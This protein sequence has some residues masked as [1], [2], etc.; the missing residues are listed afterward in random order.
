MN[1]G[2]TGSCADFVNRCGTAD[3]AYDLPVEYSESFLRDRFLALF[4]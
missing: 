4:G 2:S 3:G 1:A